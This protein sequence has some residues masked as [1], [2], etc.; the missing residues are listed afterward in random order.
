MTIVV[1]FCNASEIDKWNNEYT[2]SPRNLDRFAYKV[3]L[4]FAKNYQNTRK[5]VENLKK[6]LINN[7][8]TEDIPSFYSFVIIFQNL[9]KSLGH[10]VKP[11]RVSNAIRLS[12]PEE[13]ESFQ[14][15]FGRMINHCSTFLQVL[16]ETRL[17]FLFPKISRLKL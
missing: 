12:K 16:L 2:C 9:A 15:T 11:R 10:S 5:T 7:K 8:A 1:G 14:S 4:N 13:Y 17:N 3:N 6:K